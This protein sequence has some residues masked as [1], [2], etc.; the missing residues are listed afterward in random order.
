M[1]CFFPFQKGIQK[2]LQWVGYLSS[3]WD[4]WVGVDRLL[5][6]NEENIIRQQT[7]AKQPHVD[8]NTK[9]GQLTQMNPKSSA[10]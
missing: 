4:E 2:W 8:D 6:Q 5:K 7:L 10:G 3:S 1:N 9:S